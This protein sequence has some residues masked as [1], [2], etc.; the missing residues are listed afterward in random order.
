MVCHM[1][2]MFKIIRG[3]SSHIGADFAFD[4]QIDKYLAL[5][6]KKFHHFI[7]KNET[8]RAIVQWIDEDNSLHNENS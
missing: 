2:H 4:C 8:I 1:F 7:S 3:G 6:P 5:A